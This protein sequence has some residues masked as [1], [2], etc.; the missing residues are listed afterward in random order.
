M[1]SHSPPTHVLLKLFNEALVTA[2]VVLEWNTKN[3]FTTT[4]RQKKL[5]EDDCLLDCRAVQSGIN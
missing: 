5:H 3:S 1:A 4:K 2:V